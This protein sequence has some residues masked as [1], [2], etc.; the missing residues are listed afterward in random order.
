MIFRTETD[1]PESKEKI[2]YKDKILIMGSCFSE[3]IGNWLEENFFDIIVNPF[4]IIYNPMTVSQSL[5][6]LLNE[7]SY[8]ENDLFKLNDLYH[9]F[10]HHSRFSYTTVDE[11]L[12]YINSMMQK[13]SLQLKEASWL[14]ITFG[15]SYVYRWTEN[16]DVVANCH[17]LPAN[18]FT[19]KKLSVSDIVEEWRPLLKQL[20]EVNPN[21]NIVFTVSP[22]RHLKDTLHGNELSKATLLLAI[23]EL[24]NED[25]TLKYFPSYEIL[26]DELRDYRFYSDD[27]THPSSMAIEYI[28]ERFSETYFSKETKSTLL[29][30]QKISKAISHRPFNQNSAVYRNFLKQ[31]IDRINLL[32]NK[33]EIQTLRKPLDILNSQF[34]SLK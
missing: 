7:K 2:C 34:T 33:K 6:N 20:K 26:I 5:K 4:G 16:N 25:E 30:C 14:L 32:I 1:I 29:E 12:H 28:K 19:R 24:C 11:T 15:T 3:N 27:M 23:E 18:Q 31:T 10:D 8:N 22:I 17:K 13:A 9:S 21:L